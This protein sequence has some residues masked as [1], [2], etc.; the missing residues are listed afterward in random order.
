MENFHTGK[1]ATTK[2]SL[3]LLRALDWKVFEELCGEMLDR[4]GFGEAGEVERRVEGGIDLTFRSPGAT[5]SDIAVRCQRQEGARPVGIEPIRKFF[6]I[7][8]REGFGRKVFIT[9][10]SFTEPARG[11]YDDDS[12]L[13]LIDGYQVLEGIADFGGRVSRELLEFAVGRDDWQVPTCPDCAV[14]MVLRTARQNGSRF[15]GCAN[16]ASTNCQRTF[17]SAD[18]SPDRSAI[19]PMA[20]EDARFRQRASG[21][22]PSA[23]P[24]APESSVLAALQRRI[25]EV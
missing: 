1:V 20:A 2:W 15:W 8:R 14:K 13:A 24:H 21:T 9:T 18:G 10:S 12:G 23:L 7:S 25:G 19:L 6:G 5:A 22:P 17:P 16:S 3:E 11:E 4:A